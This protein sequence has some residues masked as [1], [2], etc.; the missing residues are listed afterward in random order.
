MAVN[1]TALGC[2][3]ISGLPLP[4]PIEAYRFEFPLTDG[5]YAV[6][7]SADGSLVQA[8]DQRYPNL[9]RGV[10][11]VARDSADSDGD[12]LADSRDDCPQIAGVTVSELRGCPQ[13]SSADRDGDGSL[14][15]LDHCP[16][17]AGAAATEGCTILKDAD[18]DGA[19]DHIDICRADSGIIHPD[20]ALGC[21]ADGSGASS[22][23][24]ASD[25]ICRVSGTDILVYGSRDEN[26]GAIKRVE[27]GPVIGRTAA[28]DWYQLTDGWVR[29]EGLQLTGACYNI[30]LVNPAVGG[31]TGCFM[32]PLGDFVNVREAPAGNQVTRLLA[33]EQQAVLGRNANGDWLFYRAGWV[34]RSVLELAGTCESLPPLDPAHVASGTIH[35]C[36]PAYA[37]LLQPRIGIGEWNAR[38]ASATLANRLRAEPDYLTEQIGEIPPGRVI[39]AVLDGPACNGPWVW[40]QVEFDGKVGWTV[41]SDF[42]AYHYY[43]EPVAGGATTRD[44]DDPTLSETAQP[45]SKRLIHSAN[46]DTLNTVAVLQ[47]PAPI[48]VAWSPKQS[49]LAALTEQGEIALFR[50]PDFASIP[51][52]L[53]LPSAVSAIAFSPDENWLAAGDKDGR[54][55]LFELRADRRSGQTHEL[56]EQA[57]PIRQLAWNRTGDKLAAISGA[58]SLRLAR[59]AGTLKL[60]EFDA[61]APASSELVLH[62]R[63]PYPLTAAA[64]SRHGRWLAVS[65][66][67]SGDGRAA[68]WVYDSDS[69]DLAFSKAL[70]PMRGGGFVLTSPSTDLGDFVYSSGD[71]LYQLHTTQGV[72]QRIHH[73]AGA[74]YS[75]IAFRPQ[76]IPGAEALMALAAE[77]RSGTGQLG[78]ANALSPHS[79]D[80]TFSAAPAA[81]AF[82]PDGRL[83]AIAET[84]QDRIRLL[85]VTA[86]Q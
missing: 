3:L 21:P 45:A 4:D 81:I 50:P 18:R 85:G 26:G 67:S 71:S 40:W 9:G 28:L 44:R 53:S 39:D 5:A 60:W 27:S 63:F 17:Q 20:F 59:Q 52:D 13:T 16:D 15:R 30:P 79:P 47:L 1:T 32:R 56:G 42:N 64:F 58:E 10:Q 55:T 41:E 74:L 22:R 65:G 57:G 12:G 84:K 19:P 24:R 68:I 66:E 14:D 77:T 72:D 86:A 38:V 34:S 80:A 78:F 6:H 46:L 73:L 75:G 2:G 54:V 37:G 70:V 29:A 62:Y 43:L 51:L 23:R 31:A 76:F 83:L 33:H 69:G 48:A 7:I 36:P 8:C 25:D 82:S 11:P 61:A 49:A 35:F